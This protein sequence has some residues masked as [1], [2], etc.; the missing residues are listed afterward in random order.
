[1]NEF[2]EGGVIP[3]IEQKSLGPW[4]DDRLRE[5]TVV[6]FAAGFVVGVGWMLLVLFV[7][8]RLVG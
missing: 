6:G 8:D 7:S 1:M 3:E 5:R 2:A 4:I